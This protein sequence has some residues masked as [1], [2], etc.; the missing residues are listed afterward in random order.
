MHHFLLISM[1]SDKKSSMKS[2]CFLPID[3]MSFSFTAFK[4]FLCVYWKGCVLVGISLSLFWLTQLCDYIGLFLLSSV[5]IF[6]PYFFEYFPVSS[7]LSS[8]SGTLMMQM[9]D[10]WFSPTGPWNCYYYYSLFYYLVYFLFI[11]Q[12][13]FFLSFLLS[14][15]PLFFFFRFAYFYFQPSSSLIPSSSPFICLWAHYGIF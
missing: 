1:A 8:F 11:I 4:I 10:F 5:E 14:L 7:S 6:V 9:L 13:C 2:N 12:I 15:S 3:N